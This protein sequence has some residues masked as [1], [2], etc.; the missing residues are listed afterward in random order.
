MED[1]E[2]RER[3][4]WEVDETK[5]DLE[6]VNTEFLENFNVDEQLVEIYKS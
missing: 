5:G 4:M 1:Q 2:D 3:W 6:S